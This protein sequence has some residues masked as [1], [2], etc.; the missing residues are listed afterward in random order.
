MYLNGEG[1]R[2]RDRWGERVTDVA[3]LTYYNAHDDVV[4]FTLPPEEYSPGWTVRIDTAEPGAR[5]TVLDAGTPLDVPARSMIVLRAEPDHE[6]TTAQVESVEGG[7]QSTPTNPAAS[8]AASATDPEPSGAE[9]SDAA[10]SDAAPSGAEP[11]DAAPSG[12]E[13]LTAS[14]EGTSATDPVNET[15]ADPDSPDTEPE[16]DPTGATA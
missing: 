15:D 5:E 11:S 2:G 8:T 6:V 1:I 12:A 10:P 3:F 14:A 9:P 13:Q 4:T 7:R 16:P